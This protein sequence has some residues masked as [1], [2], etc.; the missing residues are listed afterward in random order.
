MKYSKSEIKY[1]LWILTCPGTYNMFRLEE[2]F[3]L[4]AFGGEGATMNENFLNS[5]VGLTILGLLC[6]FLRLEFL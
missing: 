3:S 6:R 4:E 5:F 1:S 2:P